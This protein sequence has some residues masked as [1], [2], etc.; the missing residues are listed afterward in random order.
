MCPL[1]RMDSIPVTASLF[2]ALPTASRGAVAKSLKCSLA[3]RGG[4]SALKSDLSAA[5]VAGESPVT[6]ESVV[7]PAVDAFVSTDDGEYDDLLN[8]MMEDARSSVTA[9]T[10]WEAKLPHAVEAV[11]ITRRP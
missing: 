3:S 10:A 1:R 7:P 2:Y 8:E 6:L 4:A 5:M 9:S 11:A